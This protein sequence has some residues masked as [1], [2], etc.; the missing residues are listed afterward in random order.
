MQPFCTQQSTLFLLLLTMCSS[1]A[2]ILNQPV[3]KITVAADKNIKVVTVDRSL[4]TDS[5]TGYNNGPV[6]YY[7]ERGNKP[8][9]IQLRIDSTKKTVWLKAQNSVAYWY[10]ILSNYGIGT[11]VD[12]DNLKRYAYPRNNYLTLKDTTVKMHR[13]APMKKGTINLSFS[14][15]FITGYYIND[16]SGKYST[17][18]VFGIEGGIEYFHT[19]NQYLSLHA[20][21][22]TTVFGERFGSG[23]FESGHNFFASL[24]NNNIVGR[25]DLGYGISVSKLRWQQDRRDSGSI[26]RQLKKSITA[27]LSLAAQYR[28]GQYFRFGILYQPGIINTSYKPTFDYQ[29]Y[30]S[31]NLIWK[32]KVKSGSL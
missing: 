15:P 4:K 7:L 8:A 30:L 13:F 14:L 31:L 27:G 16:S 29:H 24:R 23:I 22:G 5:S 19:Q 21:A 9:F 11:L 17:T 18:G 12:K 3:Q 26:T 10:N 28:I 2:T 32:L 25:F 1:C 6:S 20:G